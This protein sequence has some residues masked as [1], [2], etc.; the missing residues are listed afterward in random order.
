VAERACSLGSRVNASGASLRSLFATSPSLSLSHSLRVRLCALSLLPLLRSL[1]LTHSLRVRLCALTL[2]PLLRSLSLTH[3][4]RVRLCALSLLPLLRS[5]SLTHSLRVRLCALSL[6]PLLRSLSLSHSLRVRL[7]RV[8]NCDDE[9]RACRAVRRSVQLEPTLVTS[10]LDMQRCVP[11][12]PWSP[13]TR[14]QPVPRDTRTLRTWPFS[15]APYRA[16]CD[17]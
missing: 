13:L 6:L 17:G 9:G 1:S 16:L 14:V 4:L 15:V 7:S 8:Q 10:L 11:S 5:L 12:H 2:L 3:S